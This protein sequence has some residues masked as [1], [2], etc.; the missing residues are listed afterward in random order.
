MPDARLRAGSIGAADTGLSGPAGSTGSSG[1][2]PF[3]DACG[4]TRAI[5]HA[6]CYPTAEP[7]RW[8]FLPGIDLK[9]A[10]FA[11]AGIFVLGAVATPRI[12]VDLSPVCSEFS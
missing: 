7:L 5:W 6:T 2:G 10:R 1:R 11:A 8:R 12:R 4:N 3:D 9:P